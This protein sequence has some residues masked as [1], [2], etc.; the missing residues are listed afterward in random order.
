[1]DVISSSMITQV[2]RHITRLDETTN[3]FHLDLGVTVTA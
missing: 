3:V 2:F 1:M